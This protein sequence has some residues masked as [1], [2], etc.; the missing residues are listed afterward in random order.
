MQA[1]VKAAFLQAFVVDDPLDVD[2]YMEQV[3]GFDDPAHLF[4]LTKNELDTIC[5]KHINMK[6]GHALK[7]QDKFH[8][9]HTL[10]NG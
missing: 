10:V 2:V 4:R 1:D 8:E 3:D 6:P 7:F 9:T 5:R